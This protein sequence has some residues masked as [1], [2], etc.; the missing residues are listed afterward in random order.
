VDTGFEEL[1]CSRRVLHGTGDSKRTGESLYWKA[2]N[3]KERF[4][5][6][7]LGRASKNP[8]ISAHPWRLSGDVCLPGGFIPR[9]QKA[10]RDRI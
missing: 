9:D 6:R 5:S 7:G 1:L 10:V 3:G 8:Q 4:S 2:T